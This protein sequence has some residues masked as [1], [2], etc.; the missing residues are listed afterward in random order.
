MNQTRCLCASSSNAAYASSG[1]CSCQSAFRPYLTRN[2]AT[3]EYLSGIL[4]CTSMEEEDS[5]NWSDVIHKA[6]EQ[7]EA[8]EA[9][10]AYEELDPLR[11]TEDSPL[12][13]LPWD[14]SDVIDAE[15]AAPTPPEQASPAA[16]SAPSLAYHLT[17][18]QPP[19]YEELP[20]LRSTSREGSP[21]TPLP[22]DFSDVIDAEV[23]EPTPPAE[24]SV[25]VSPSELSSP[26]KSGDKIPMAP[27]TLSGPTLRSCSLTRASAPASDEQ[28][29]LVPPTAGP[30]HRHADGKPT[31]DAAEEQSGDLQQPPSD[32][33][34]YEDRSGGDY[35]EE[36]GSNPQPPGPPILPGK[37]RHKPSLRRDPPTCRRPFCSTR[38]RV[39]ADHP[40]DTH[41]DTDEDADEDVNEEFEDIP[42]EPPHHTRP[43]PSRRVATRRTPAPNH[44]DR[45]YKPKGTRETP[46]KIPRRPVIIL[47]DAELKG[48]HEKLREGSLELL[49]LQLP[50]KGAGKLWKC[51]ECSH[52]SFRD[53][54]MR[55]HM[56]THIPTL[57]QLCWNPACPKLFARIDSVQRHIQRCTAKLES[58]RTVSD[59]TR[60]VLKEETL[61]VVK[62]KTLRV[63]NEKTLKKTLRVVN[64]KTLKKTLRVLK[65]E[66][67]RVVEETNDYI[68]VKIKWI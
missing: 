35:D 27:R 67:L 44:H 29:A 10:E 43:G 37:S 49:K 24:P 20:P 15:V 52:T 23:V 28:H 4:L 31:D 25:Y 17:L 68:P 53:E 47:S 13:L 32:N 64:E 3:R 42:L 36:S 66:T 59:E 6:N 41:K 48:I 26:P 7:F 18:V 54:E 2:T 12:T 50:V 55:R 21:L 45:V 5:T 38:T 65:E 34:T 51:D 11:T 56:E 1:T 40:E 14:F 63:V 60:R 8:G 57:R 62:E 39:G 22:W 9:S 16:S 46:P 33:G 19:Q 30:S 58:G 61:R